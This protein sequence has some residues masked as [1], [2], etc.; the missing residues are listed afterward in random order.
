LWI[1]GTLCFSEQAQ[2]VQNSY[3]YK[4]YP[5]QWKFSGQLC[6]SQGKL[7]CSKILNSKKYIQYSEKFQGKLFSGQAQIVKNPE[8]KNYIY[9][10]ENFQGNFVFSGQ[11]Q[12]KIFNTVY[13]HL[14]AIRVI[15]ASVVCNLDQRHD[16]L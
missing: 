8:Y 4:V 12:E 11:A 5:T 16:W 13:I 10:S 1:Q 14:G 15:W 7:S 9:Y 6:F 2:V 3:M